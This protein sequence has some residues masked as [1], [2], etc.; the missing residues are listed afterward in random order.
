MAR[1][2]SWIA[3]ALSG[4]AL[5]VAG[6]G[7]AQRDATDAAISAAQ[8][9]IN[10][11][12]G[13]A[14]KYVPE[15]L[16]A[17]QAALQKAKDALAKEDYQAAL[18]AAQDATNKARDL[19]VAA[20]AKKDELNKGWA[21]LKVSMPKSLDAVKAKLNAYAHGARLPVGLDKDKLE[22]AKTQY[23]QL[24]QV[25]ADASAAAAQGDLG[26]AMKKAS[27]IKDPLAKLMEL[28]GIKS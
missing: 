9:A 26:E 2:A 10:A 13:E 6:C 4:I 16:Q 22:E 8:A 28:L 19:A 24:K 21:D 17:A 11:V 23:E 5:L 3:C 18:K 20:A 12:Q 27:A 25:W 15:Q 14:E 7:N 1:K